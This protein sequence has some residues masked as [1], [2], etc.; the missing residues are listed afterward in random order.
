EDKQNDSKLTSTINDGVLALR[1]VGGIGDRELPS[2]AKYEIGG[3]GT[4]R[5]YDYKEFSG[6]ISLVFNAEFRFP[7]SDNVQGVVFADLGN[8]WNYGESIAITDLKFGKGFGI[9]FDTFI[10]PISIDYGI[11]EDQEGQAYF[12]IGHSF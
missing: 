10:G 8:A 5:G 9:R 1:A 3:L 2:F 4:V 11:G 12:S 6:D 7:L